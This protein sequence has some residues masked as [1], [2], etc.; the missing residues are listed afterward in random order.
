MATAPP[1]L[2]PT[3][4]MRRVRMPARGPGRRRCAGPRPSAPRPAQT[5][6]PGAS[7]EAALVVGVGRD[8]ALGPPRARPGGRRRRGRSCRAGRRSPPRARSRPPAQVR[9]PRAVVDDEGV[10]L[11]RA[12]RRTRPAAS[13]AAGHRAW[14]RRPGPAAA[15]TGREARIMRQ[16][17]SRPAGEDRARPRPRT[18]DCASARRC[19]ATTGAA[20]AGSSGT[21]SRQAAD[22]LGHV[23]LGP[24]AQRPGLGIAA[25]QQGQ[26]HLGQGLQQPR[27]PQLGAARRRRIVAALRSGARDSRRPW[28]PRRCRWSA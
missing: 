5:P 26:L 8:P 28:P 4:A 24:V 7:A 20:S 18:T 6:R 13:A 27:P 3:T 12:G 21:Y 9:Q 11:E 16:D 23:G 1:M 25:D 10:R 17:V 22:R 15:R 19:C 2:S 14:R